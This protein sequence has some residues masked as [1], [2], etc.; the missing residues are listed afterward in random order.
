MSLHISA[1][2]KWSCSCTG[3]APAEVAASAAAAKRESVVVAKAAMPPLF[4]PPCEAGAG[5]TTRLPGSVAAGAGGGDGD[6]HKRTLSGPPPPPSRAPAS[7]WVLR[8]HQRCARRSISVAP[9]SRARGACTRSG[10]GFFRRPCF[11]FA[12]DGGSRAG[13]YVSGGATRGRFWGGRVEAA[14]PSSSVEVVE[15]ARKARNAAPGSHGG[16]ASASREGRHHSSSVSCSRPRPRRSSSS[17]SSFARVARSAAAPDDSPR[18]VSAGA[19]VRNFP[20][21]PLCCCAACARAFRR[22]VSELRT[23]SVNSGWSVLK[24][25]PVAPL[26]NAAS[27]PSLLTSSSGVSG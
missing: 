16:S 17:S 3:E 2:A 12:A 6:S 5:A 23:T 14:S 1:S 19:L 8:A 21:A 25:A 4:R 15:G 11:G 24:A 7:I 13:S 18:S 26:R 22:R 9:S 20:L 10:L 27:L